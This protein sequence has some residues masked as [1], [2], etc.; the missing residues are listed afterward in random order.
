MDSSW[1][2]LLQAAKFRATESRTAV[3]DILG[4]VPSCRERNDCTPHTAW[5]SRKLQLTGDSTH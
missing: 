1:W 3:V 4:I 2:A 5:I